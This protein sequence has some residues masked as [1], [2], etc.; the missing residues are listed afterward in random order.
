MLTYWTVL[1]KVVRSP[2]LEHGAEILKK[3]TL[4]FHQ[5]DQM[6]GDDNRVG[7]RLNSEDSIP[8]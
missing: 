6:D 4:Y 2:Q 5:Q 7:D 8:C 1:Q 3:T